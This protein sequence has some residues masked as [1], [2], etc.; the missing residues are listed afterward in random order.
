VVRTRILRLEDLRELRKEIL[1]ITARHGARNVRVFGSVARGQARIDSDIDLLVE[2]E[3]GRTVLDLSSLILDL[4]DALDC[5][6]NVVEVIPGTT[7]SLVEIIEREAVP[8]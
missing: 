6:V 2:F 4:R 5:E 8:L 1:R 7:S 3:P